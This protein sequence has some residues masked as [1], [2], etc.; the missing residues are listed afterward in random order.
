MVK[1]KLTLEQI[2]KA[3]TGEYRY[4]STLSL[5]SALEGVSVQNNVPAAL[6]PGKTWYL[7]CR[8]LGGLQGR[9][10]EVRKASPPTGIRSPDRPA[11]SESLYRL[12]YRGSLWLCD[13]LFFFSIKTKNLVYVPTE[14]SITS[15]A[16]IFYSRKFLLK[17]PCNNLQFN[18]VL[19]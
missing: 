10:G 12:S 5:T 19:I 18:S 14:C 11:H 13:S 15:S 3:Q 2:T 16:K 9:F 17:W 7:M 4:S 6:P 8:R 1:V